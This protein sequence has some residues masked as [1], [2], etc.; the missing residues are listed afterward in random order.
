MDAASAA[1]DL[2][3]QQ[4]DLDAGSGQPAQN[5]SMGALM[6]HMDGEGYS[7]PARDMESYTGRQTR[8]VRAPSLRWHVVFLQQLLR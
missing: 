7:Y 4:Q 8:Q 6:G 5:M 2:V 3:K 1:D